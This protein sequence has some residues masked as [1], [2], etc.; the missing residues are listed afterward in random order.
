MKKS[1]KICFILS[2]LS[3]CVPLFSQSLTENQKKFITG[4]LADKTS[5]VRKSSGLE[6]K[7]LSESALDFIISYAPLLGPDR[8]LSALAIAS[9]LTVPKD[10]GGD[11]EYA[12]R[13]SA[14]LAKVFELC[15]DST[16]RIA[17]IEK[18]S[19][20][21]AL[22]SSKETAALLNSFLAEKEG[23]NAPAGDVINTAVIA[24]GKIGNTESFKIMYRVWSRNLW[25]QY[26]AS[27]NDSLILLSGRSMNEVISIIS[28]G[29]I[30]EIDAF[31]TL[32]AK[33]EKIS[34]NFIAE[35]AENA[36]LKTIHI[37]EEMPGTA[38][39]TVH[40]QLESLKVVA[41]NHWS[42]ASQIVL[43]YFELAKDEYKK[44]IL[45][46][47]DFISV[48][49]NLKLLSSLETSAA[50]SSY[51]ADLNKSASAG[52]IPVESVVLSVISALGE[53][54]DKAAFDNLLYVTY[55]NYPETVIAA[56]R[57]ALQ[58]LKW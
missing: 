51:L 14:K 52:A 40:L 31:F 44:N 23:S 38:S 1:V 24:L 36:L 28:T 29:T 10:G 35:I 16:I 48:I 4:N 39:Q 56:A 49:G 19:N 20:L 9:A 30:E 43:R 55:L 11:K 17:V 37:A 8:E 33:S 21:S 25:E 6:A 47:E 50:L 58:K 18:L 22:A 41:E 42:K 53:L 34:K 32:L 7:D 12:E 15:D 3:L 2:L 57:E 27:I 45:S 46:A 5:A 54:G 13:I 26:S